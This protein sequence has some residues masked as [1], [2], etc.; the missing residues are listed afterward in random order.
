MASA[1]GDRRR[2]LITGCS[3]GLGLSMAVEL[4]ASG[5]L[6][7]ATMRNPGKRH[8]LDLAVKAVGGDEQNIRV[9]QLDVTDTDSVQSAL[10]QISADSGGCLDALINNAG[11]NAEACFEDIDMADIRNM[12]DTHVLGTM[13]V[14][15][16]A[17]PLLRNSSDARIIFMSSWGAVFGMPETAIYAAAK[18]AVERLAEALLWELAPQGIQVSVMRPGFHRSKIFTDNSGRVRPVESRYTAV[19]QK[20]DPVARVVVGRARDPANLARKVRAVLDSRNPGFRHKV[21][22][23]SHLVAAMNPVI[24]HRFRRAVARLAFRQ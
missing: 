23:D 22:F 4:A 7:Y 2:V 5:W 12:F 15:R 9:L 8:D 10:A 16:A 17:L 19:Y 20:M 18:A 1:T 3:S 13:A 14:T 11:L 6:V 21:G 24:P